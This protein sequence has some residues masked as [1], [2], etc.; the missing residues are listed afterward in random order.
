M[1]NWRIKLSLLLT[2][3]VFAILLN[4][5]G[6][7]I[8]QVINNFDISKPSASILEGFKD[9][10]IALVSFLVASYL[11]RFGYRKAI[12]IGLTLV[13]IAC[14]IMP[15][16][17]SFAM[18]KVLFLSVGIGFA[19]VKVSVYSTV[20]L[21]THNRQEHASFLNI[22]EG[23]FMVG[24]L[25]GYWIFGFFITPD[26]PKSLD[27]FEVYYWLALL[28]TIN[29]LLLLSTPFE[30]VDATENKGTAFDEFVAMIK[31]VKIPMVYVFV[32]SAFLYVLIEQGIGTWLPTFNNEVLHLPTDIS[33]QVTSIFA[34][35]LAIGRLGAGAILR[36]INWYVLL[37]A[38][39]LGMAIL[40]LLTLPLTK[41]LVVNANVDWHNLPLAAWLF[42]FIGLF[43]APIYPAINSVILSALPQRRHAAM[44]GLIVL[45]SA[46]GGTTGSMITGVVFSAFDGQ[47]A[48]YFTLLP[49]VVIAL[50]LAL[51]KSH[52]ESNELTN[53]VKV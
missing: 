46:L 20:G 40:I 30:Q 37:N 27:W 26:E 3:F 25:S 22:I 19:L 36:R 18:S 47:T 24:V 49:I 31:L 2:Y 42:P 35:C 1:K 6:V 38:C 33:V 51:L 8:L 7:V 5:V 53:A 43:M 11:P 52:V 21:I 13:T 4:S 15:Q 10:P 39:L 23:F 9:L 44:T 14:L 32:I 29:I 50:M 28:C 48:F 45:F 17:P 16:L 34:A 41:D 12:L